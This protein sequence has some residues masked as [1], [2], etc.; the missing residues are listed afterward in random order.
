MIYLI[1]AVLCS[2]SI[3][4]ILRSTE[5]K[6]SSDAGFFLANYAVCIVLSALYLPKG[7][8]TLSAPGTGTALLLGLLSGIL[9]LVSFVA[10][11]RSIER[12]GVVLSAIFMRLGIV[13]T[14]LLSIAFFGE[15]PD[16]KQILGILFAFS[17]IVILNFDK[18]GLTE[19]GSMPQL[20]L[21]FLISGATECML[22]I[23]DS[24]GNPALGSTYL[25]TTFAIAFLSA[26]VMQA[27]RKEKISKWDLL[28]GA[29]LGIPNY[30]SSRF[31]M[32]ALQRVPNVIAYPA[33]SVSVIVAT[34]I[35]GVLLFREK[36]TVL[37]AAGFLMVLFALVLLS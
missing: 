10:H 17:A 23:F 11:L 31:M 15:R 1:L 24:V 22:N 8:V 35:L 12:N 37:K 34:G 25:L 36:M 27:L 20:F 21:L 14:V 7:S 5:P 28:F 9:Y 3:S 30:Y 26:A 2:T 32:L 13:L 16:G 6:R 29:V 33:Y 4:V 19:G 18:K